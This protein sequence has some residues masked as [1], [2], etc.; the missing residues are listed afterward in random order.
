[1]DEH[2]IIGGV[3]AAAIARAVGTPV[4]VY[5]QGLMEAQLAAY[6]KGLA[7]EAFATQVLYA[8]KAFICPAMVRLAAE[9]GA[10]QDVVSGNELAMALA[11]GMPADRIV[12]HGNNKTPDEMA[13]GLR[14]GVTM[15]VDSLAEAQALAALS[16][17]G[18]AIIRINPHIEA[19][20]HRYD[21]TAGLD[22]KFGVAIDDVAAI[23]RTVA[24]LDAG[25]IE[26][27]G[28]HAHIGSQ[29]M[30]TAGF[31]AAI[32]ALTGLARRLADDG[33]AVR[34]LDLGGGFAARYTAADSPLDPSAVGRL[35]A[36]AV[37]ASLARQGLSL[38]KVM[39]EPG[40]SI[41]AEAA[42]ELYT[43][44]F[45]KR[46]PHKEYLFVDGGMADNIRPALYQARYQ[47]LLDG[48]I[49]QPAD[50]RYTV[51]GK[52]CESGDILIE[53]ADLPAAHPGDLLAVLSTGAYG[54]SMASNYNLLARPAVVFAKDGRARLVIRREA[55]ADLARL[56]ADQPL[57]L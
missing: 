53:Q 35:I 31:V 23:E 56:A 33:I 57:D 16:I 39:I 6:M 50:H 32:E 42:T 1:M 19:H 36:S 47:C 28:L 37:S 9:A 3:P 5:D 55:Y 41:V 13:A 51:A 25:G 43:V 44:G 49:G 38:S 24:A 14:A 21:V 8:S 34:W 17:G 20:T 12:F 26:F 48:K 27:M 22:S 46:T 15:A 52:C 18:R 30:E 10:G 7:S 4:I 45:T 29:I 40:R 11:G 54:Y 2:L